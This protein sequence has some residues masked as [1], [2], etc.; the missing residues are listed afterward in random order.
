MS[1]NEHA[2]E[3]PRQQ[4]SRKWLIIGVI[5][6]V[7]VIAIVLAI[8]FATQGSQDGPSNGS[9]TSPSSSTTPAP[10]ASD[11][12]SPSP[13]ES[14]PA[15]QGPLPF[16]EPGVI[17]GDLT[18]RVASIEAV[19]GEAQGPGE[20]AGPAL[21]FTVVITNG[22]DQSAPLSNAVAN[23]F[24]SDALVPASAL[25]G[26]GTQGFPT[27]IGAGEEATA[28]YVFAVPVDGRAFVQLSVDYSADTNDVV[29]EGPAPTE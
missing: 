22:T 7:A 18:V 17:A 14:T 4:R 23:L 10:T 15:A 24:Y 12:S 16:D 9:S 28:V 29:F 21:R 26:P 20:S 3:Q 6:V 27:A 2:P 13:T 8:V 5:V 11:S 25:S 1:T 19:E